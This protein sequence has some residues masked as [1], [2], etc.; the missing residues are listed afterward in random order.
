MTAAWV[1]I[2]RRE[3]AG[4]LAGFWI[5]LACL[6]LGVWAIAASGSITEGFSHGLVREARMLLGGDASLNVSQRLAT[7]AERAWMEERGVVSEAVSVDGMGRS[8]DIVRQVELRGVDGGYPLV[9]E[10]AL[11]PKMKLGDALAKGADGV[12]GA[13][14]SRK[15]LDDFKLK[16]GD[17][18]DVGGIKLTIRAEIKQEPDRIGAPN[19]F[20]PEA[21]VS[22]DALKEA[23]MLAAGRLFRANYRLALKPEAVAT[24]A[25][26]AKAKWDEAG[27]RY[28]APEDAIDGLRNL[29]SMLNSFMAV[30][31]VAS[32][33]AGGV[34]VAQ[35]TQSFLETRVD[36]IAALKALGADAGTIRAAYALQLGVLAAV[37]S[38]IG[39]A[40]G[41]ASP[42]AMDYFAGDR[43]PLPNVLGFYPLPLLKAFLLGL[44]A[45]VV[46]AA[47]PLGKARATR[48]AALFRGAGDARPTPTP[49]RIASLVCAV[50][51]AGLATWGSPRPI[52]TF[53]LLVGAAA[54]YLM[55]IGAAVLI[56]RAARWGSR[57]VRG[58]GRLALA[59]LGGPGSLAPTVAP[60]L[61]LGLALLAMVGTVQA[62]L[63]R[64]IESTAP[65]NGPSV[66]FRQI[67]DTDASAFDAFMASRGVNIAEPQTYRRT[68]LVLGRVVK[69]KGHDLKPEDV[70]PDERWVVR[71]E[72]GMTYVAEKPPEAKLTSG[73]WW[74]TNYTGPLLV[75]VEAGAAKGLNLGVG[76]TIGFRIFGRDL[77][78]KV[79]SIRRVDWATFGQN[80][81]FVL[82]PGTLEAAHPFHAAIAKVDPKIEDKLVADI[83]VRFP[84]VLAFQ[85]RRAL[86]TAADLFQQVAFVV[87]F[88]A[89]VV[90]LA[91]VLVLFGALAAATRRRRT[92]AAL[93]KTF[94]AT[95]IGVL[96]LYAAEFAL[97]GAAAALLGGAV[98]VA[99][100]YPVVTEV[101][102]A[103]W[104][105]ELG[106]ALLAAGIATLAAAAGGAMVGWATLSRSPAGVLRSA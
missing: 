53:G 40:L 31:G 23:D 47:P 93:L 57:N 45:A 60:A 50:L 100:A 27:L 56:K 59:N 80:L 2:A 82:S 69:L 68:P 102:E 28:R 94:G 77:E 24:F 87:N 72:I 36:S 25:N 8:G 12:W 78:A 101:F 98:G 84:G 18:A 76:D 90:T 75:S 99:A 32:L 42:F 49:E 43:I 41:A 9:G 97:A 38:L 19:T 52:A 105:L 17:V 66:V 81:A 74:P 63:L 62:N 37:G 85:I 65:Q 71:G 34:G 92:E 64:Q 58:F 6:A 4:G 3:L 5:Y 11:A 54:T 10:V 88:L 91:G 73:A 33:V 55:L 22:I 48:P 26:D 29:I 30:V 21:Y 13:A 16:V 35:A 79:A 96:G 44:L 89:G 106:P 83:S 86:E 1:R 14:V 103:R 15:F 67:K 95:R 46:F 51:L 7:P 61:G 39:V 20:Q 104:T 70:S